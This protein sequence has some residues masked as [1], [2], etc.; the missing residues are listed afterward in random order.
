MIRRQHQ[1]REMIRMASEKDPKKVEMQLWEIIPA[2]EGN[3]F[4]HR[5]VLH[6]R[7]V[8]TARTKP[9][10]DRCCLSDICR[11]AGTF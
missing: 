1:S 11:S 2:E 9:Y 10:C 7:E 5:L 3:A 6:G 4:C 8:C